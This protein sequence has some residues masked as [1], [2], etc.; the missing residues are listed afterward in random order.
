L[1]MTKIGAALTEYDAALAVA[2][3]KVQP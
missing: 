3:K 2:E 1:A